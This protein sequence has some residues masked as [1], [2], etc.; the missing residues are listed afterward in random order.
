MSKCIYLSKYICIY[1]HVYDHQFDCL[2]KR[3]RDARPHPGHLVLPRSSCIPSA[4]VSGPSNHYNL[5]G[6]ACE[7]IH[8]TL[9]KCGS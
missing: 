7:Q 6:K 3:Q 9:L 2:I 4:C 8:A 5:M 1:N